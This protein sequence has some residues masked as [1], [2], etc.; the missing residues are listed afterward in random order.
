MSSLLRVPHVVT[1][2]EV[3]ACAGCV[4]LSAI[5]ATAA[6]LK[7]RSDA[8]HIVAADRIVCGRVE[9][10]RTERRSGSGVI[11]TVARLRVI[12]D[13][14]GGTDRVL[15]IRELGGT[16]G[17]T[18]LRVPGAA[19]FVVDEPLRVRRISPPPPSHRQDPRRGHGK[20]NSEILRL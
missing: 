1:F 3:L 14:T 20:C 12:D 5:S 13:Y 11:E 17:D 10:V 18:T 9:A 8:E 2:L 19:Q 16:V 7:A 15:E 4:W 6:T